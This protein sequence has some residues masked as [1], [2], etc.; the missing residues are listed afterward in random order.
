[1]TGEDD[2]YRFD[3]WDSLLRIGRLIKFSRRRQL[4]KDLVTRAM[5]RQSSVPLI[6][7]EQKGECC[8]HPN[9]ELLITN[10]I[11][12]AQT[13][14]QSLD[15]VIDTRWYPHIHRSD[16]ILFVHRLTNSDCISSLSSIADLQ[17]VV[18]VHE[19]VYIPRL[20]SC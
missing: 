15:P 9:Y 11:H 13:G 19:V 5:A 6:P 3:I 4:R 2:L 1:M 12:Q 18:V 7:E 14:T 10:N 17:I 8:T 20:T 16:I